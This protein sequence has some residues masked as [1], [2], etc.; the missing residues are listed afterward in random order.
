MLLPDVVFNRLSTAEPKLDL[1]HVWL[2]YSFQKHLLTPCLRPGRPLKNL[3]RAAA[4]PTPPESPIHRPLN[5]DSSRTGV[6]KRSRQRHPSSAELSDL[7]EPRLGHPNSVKMMPAA[8]I[9]GHH[10]LY[11]HSDAAW[12]QST[13]QHQAAA[14]P[15]SQQQHYNRI[16]A[17]HS[18]VSGLPSAHGHDGSHEPLI[19]EDNRRTMAYIADL[20]NENTR[21]TALLELSKKR[22]QVP[23][24]AL[25]LWHSFGMST[26]RQLLLSWKA[27]ISQ[28]CHDVVIAGDHLGLYTIEPVPAHRRGVQ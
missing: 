1:G 27:N 19:S 4:T 7:D 8:H 15:A 20:L 10:Q 25:I 21:E 16:P 22:E 11:P 5:I 9:Y 6:L 14:P 28:R 2:R 18:A 17:L 3:L 26:P 23:E 13:Q 24:L 12:V